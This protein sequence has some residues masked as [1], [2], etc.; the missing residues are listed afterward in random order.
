MS[1]E[2]V[3]SWTEISTYQ[4]CPRKYKHKYVNK[5][6]VRKRAAY[7]VLG[8]AIHKYIEMFY[9][10]KDAKLAAH[11]VERVFAG[12]DR[13]LLDREETHGLEID[14]NIALGIA[15]AYPK[16]Y[17]KDFD[18][19]EKFLTEQ[20]FKFRFPK[21]T[22]SNVEVPRA[23]RG[24]I[25]CLLLDDD[26]YWWILETKTAAPSTIGPNYFKRT[27]IDGQI[28][29]YMHGAKDIL[30]KY[31]RGIIYNVIKKPG[32]RLKK[33]E[34]LQAF[35]RRVYD[36]YT[37]FADKKNYF[38]RE[39]VIV[40]QARL[41]EWLYE[42]NILTGNLTYATKPGANTTYW[43]MHTTNCNAKFGTCE[44]LP[45][46]TARQYNKVLYTKGSKR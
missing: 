13:S 5:V 44:Y 45:A 27:H 26:G 16:Y 30:G 7:F 15:K 34:S 10:T 12:V 41:D 3:F 4:E 46:C 9:R 1:D 37:Q 32:I 25:D 6:Y 24:M 36:E 20:Q 22:D 39:E 40:S 43:P 2:R 38:I 14:K 8:E 21:Q 18:R 42:T 23:F 29:S 31:P 35:Q 11:A 33:N 17:R 19:Y 28:M